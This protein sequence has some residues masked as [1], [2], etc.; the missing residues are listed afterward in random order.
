MN[1]VPFLAPQQTPQSLQGLSKTHQLL[2]GLQWVPPS[3][4]AMQALQQQ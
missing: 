1:F 2:L 3:T 4:K